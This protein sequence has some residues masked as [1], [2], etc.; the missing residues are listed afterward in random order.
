MIILSL[1]CCVCQRVPKCATS[2]LPHHSTRISIR[3]RSTLNLPE[4]PSDYRTWLVRTTILNITFG[5]YM[6]NYGYHYRTFGE[7]IPPPSQ[8]WL[9]SEWRTLIPTL[10]KLL[11]F[12][13]IQIHAQELSLQCICTVEREYIHSIE[14]AC[15]GTSLNN[16][17]PATSTPFILP[18]YSISVP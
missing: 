1:C 13:R 5:I 14:N 4:S 6:S 7:D 17:C 9:E 18:W 16:L 15:S 12:N 8:S 3:L 11:L 10:M 2:S